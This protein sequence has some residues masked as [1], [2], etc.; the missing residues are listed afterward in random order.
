MII[1]GSILSST[2]IYSKAKI[3]TLPQDF[4][5]L[6]KQITQFIFEDNFNQSVNQLPSNI[7][8]LK[9][10]NNFNQS[11]NQLPPNITHLNIWL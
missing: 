5:Q 3:F 7:T 6:P 1:K 2:F 8:H 11:V 4:S 9:F 10:G